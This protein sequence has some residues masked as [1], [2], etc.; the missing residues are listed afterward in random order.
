MMLIFLNLSY[1]AQIHQSMLAKAPPVPPLTAMTS[2]EGTTPQQNAPPATDQ[3]QNE[4]AVNGNANANNDFELDPGHAQQNLIPEPDREV[5]ENVHEVRVDAA[6]GRL[7]VGF[8]AEVTVTRGQPVVQKARDDRL[9]TWAAIGLTI[10]I[11]VLLVKK[12][13]KSSGLGGYVEGF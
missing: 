6:A 11:V 9:Y 10:A 12:V 7:R 3:N 4:A 8:R 13:L 1:N 2:S 5:V